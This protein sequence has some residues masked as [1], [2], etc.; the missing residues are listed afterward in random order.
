VT[1]TVEAG[2]AAAFD[3]AEAGQPTIAMEGAVEPAGAA[4]PGPGPVKRENKAQA[5]FLSAEV[6]YGAAG[7]AG[8]LFSGPFFRVLEQGVHV[9]DDG[10]HAVL[11]AQRLRAAPGFRLPVAVIDGLFQMAAV[12]EMAHGRKAVLPTGVAALWWLARAPLD[13]EATAC[14]RPSPNGEDGPVFDGVIRVAG[15]DVAIA[16]GMVFRAI[17]AASR[18]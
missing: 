4:P 8:W 13:G 2:G 12:F 10:V 17:D 18:Q 7:N 16:R 9:G 14:V 11:P 5:R 1:A 6:L 15:Q 3:V